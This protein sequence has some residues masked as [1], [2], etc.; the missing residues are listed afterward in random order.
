M[1]K[2]LITK[3]SIFQYFKFFTSL[4]PDRG[5]LLERKAFVKPQFYLFKCYCIC[6]STQKIMFTTVFGSWP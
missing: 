1:H 5:L 2:K 3:N 6:Q 4:P